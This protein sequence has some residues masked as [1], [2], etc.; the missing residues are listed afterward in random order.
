MQT[1]SGAY[2]AALQAE[3]RIYNDCVDVHQL[4]PV[5]HYW[6]NRFIRPQLQHYGFESVPAVFLDALASRAVPGARY[7]SLGA[8]NC[9][10]EI[11]LA[12]GLRQRGIADFT[13][14]CADLNAPMLSRGA[15]AAHKAGVG[16]NLNFIE[17]DLNSWTLQG[18]YNA[19]LAN[20]ALHHVVNL[21]HLFRSVRASL[22][23]DG[24]VI[25]SDMVGRNGHMRWP[26]AREAVERLWT[27]LPP[28]YRI[29]RRFGIYQQAFEDWD[30]SVEGFEGVRA[31]DIV[32]LL[33][34]SFHPHFFFPYSNL[35]D[36]FVDRPYGF[37]FDPSL[38]PDRDFI[39]FVHALDER[40]LTSGAL[41][42]THLIAIFGV[43]PAE[44]PVCRKGL[45]PECCLRTEAP[46]PPLEFEM[47]DVMFSREPAAE[48][49]LF[50]G[51]MAEAREVIRIRMEWALVKEAELSECTG[52]ALA[53]DA[54][55]SELHREYGVRTEWALRLQR[56]LAHAHAEIHRLQ[57]EFETRTK[58]ALA[59]QQE[60]RL[61]EAAILELSAARLT[62]PPPE[63][64]RR[65][66]L[67][68][69]FSLPAAGR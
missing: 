8:G 62:P 18:P 23:E 2:L 45:T 54:E 22:T 69:L 49:A 28:S 52:W 33:C 64:P 61:A 16:S 38:A 42:P 57:G 39:E 4:P 10:F 65:T 15:A 51:R 6:S 50:T 44:N 11:E 43:R 14:D 5:F 53:L 55:L 48:L 56:E 17:A 67:S 25:V 47:P 26:E 13:I 9:D 20:Q 3:R 12:T 31:Q 32:P 68:R 21:E 37:N 30:C 59:L 66:V 46:P 1:A 24:L 63:P 34:E 58:W 7:L 60:Q 41:T 29:N 36:V 35:I 40:G 19:A 27:K